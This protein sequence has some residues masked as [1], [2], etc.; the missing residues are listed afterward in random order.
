MA[1][2][3]LNE[4]FCEMV[5]GARD[6]CEEVKDSYMERIPTETM[7][8]E[9]NPDIMLNMLNRLTGKK[10][11]EDK[12]DPYLAYKLLEYIKSD[13]APSLGNLAEFMEM[14]PGALNAGDSPDTAAPMKKDAGHLLLI[15]Q[16]A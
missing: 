8:A 6:K 11:K 4:R 5:E 7:S 15:E 16:A 14:D 2:P 10:L 12:I 1:G 13:N 9:E 3:T